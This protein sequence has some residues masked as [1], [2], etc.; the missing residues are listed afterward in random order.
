M[1]IEPL[2]EKDWGLLRWPV[3]VF[4]ITCTLFVV[5][6]Y[7]GYLEGGS[8][9]IQRAEFLLFG[10][11]GFSIGMAFG[12]RYPDHKNLWLAADVVWLS[13]VFLTIDRLLDSVERSITHT[14]VLTGIAHIAVP[15]LHIA[16]LV[17]ALAFR[18]GR[19]GSELNRNNKERR[20]KLQAEARKRGT[21]D[22]WR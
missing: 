13:C 8:F 7:G 21:R 11:L 18:V 19:V 9:G 1:K 10:V 15:Y 17:M 6:Y 12:Y 4:L 5:L 2:T 20:A 3:W 22:D 16:F 14:Q